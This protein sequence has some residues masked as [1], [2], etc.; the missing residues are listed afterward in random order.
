MGRFLSITAGL[1][2]GAAVGAATVLLLTPRSG[3][4]TKQMIRDRFDEIVAEGQR[5]A[6]TR[7]LELTERF[8]ALKQ[9]STQV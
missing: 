5:A 7:R 9:P 2:L 1:A 6:E 3:E 4:E 8:E